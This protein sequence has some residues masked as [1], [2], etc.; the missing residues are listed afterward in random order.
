MKLIGTKQS[1]QGHKKIDYIISISMTE[2]ELIKRFVCVATSKVL[3]NIPKNH[4]LRSTHPQITKF[5]EK[6]STPSK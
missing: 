3:K 1:K 5:L 2:M 4:K 6:L